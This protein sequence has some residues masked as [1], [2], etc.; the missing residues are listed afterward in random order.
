MIKLVLLISVFYCEHKAAH[1]F[2]QLA[3][4]VKCRVQNFIILFVGICQSIFIK[5]HLNVKSFKAVSK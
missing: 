5:S 3:S 1:Y 4:I 2:Y